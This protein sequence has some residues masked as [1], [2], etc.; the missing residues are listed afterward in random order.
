MENFQG[1]N[2]LFDPRTFAAVKGWKT[3]GGKRY[4]FNSQGVLQKG[5]FQAGNYW[6]YANSEGYREKGWK[7][8]NGEMYYFK[9]TNGRMIAG[10]TAVIR[11][12][13]YTFGED[14]A[15]LGY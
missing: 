13:S 9:P 8:I 15:W 11:G 3:I 10:R 5:I 14:G 2:L 1:K 4:Y 6:Y 12:Q 7:I